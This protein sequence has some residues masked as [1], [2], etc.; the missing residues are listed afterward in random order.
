MLIVQTHDAA[1]AWKFLHKRLDDM[2][3]SPVRVGRRVED[4]LVA[5]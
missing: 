3:F 4:L 1:C 2:V 5:V